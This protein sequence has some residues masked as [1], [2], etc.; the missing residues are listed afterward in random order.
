M[1]SIAKEKLNPS[2]FTK[3]KIL[4]SHYNALTRAHAFLIGFNSKR[5]KSSYIAI[6]VPSII[7]AQQLPQSAKCLLLCRGHYPRSASQLSSFRLGHLAIRGVD[8]IVM[9]KCLSLTRVLACPD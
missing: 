9:H 1:Q 6:E 8:M 5:K 7:K 4:I 3:I 2:S